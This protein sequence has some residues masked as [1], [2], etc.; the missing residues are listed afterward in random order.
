MAD[1]AQEA[2]P[3][4]PIEYR[5]IDK[6]IYTKHTYTCLSIIG[7]SC[8]L[9]G[10]AVGHQKKLPL[11]KAAKSGPTCRP[12]LPRKRVGQTP[13]NSCETF[14]QHFPLQKYA[15][16]YISGALWKIVQIGSCAVKQF[17][18]ERERKKERGRERTEKNLGKTVRVSVRTKEGTLTWRPPQTM[19][20]PLWHS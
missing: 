18:S 1:R 9:R 15:K 4:G 16:L 17:Y 10:Q 7:K 6:W 8:L 11:R 13:E 12:R 3:R 2:G 5:C 14:G 20:L 19:V